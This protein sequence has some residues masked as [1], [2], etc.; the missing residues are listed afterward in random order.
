VNE[1]TKRW[2]NI[3]DASSTINKTIGLIFCTWLSSRT[4]LPILV[5]DT[6]HFSQTKDITLVG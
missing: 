5:Q 3:F 4:T 2:N 6:P 1:Q